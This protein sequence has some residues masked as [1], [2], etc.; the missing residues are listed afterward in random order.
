[1]ESWMQE[2]EDLI[3]EIQIEKLPLSLR[4]GMYLY[5]TKPLLFSG[6]IETNRGKLEEELGNG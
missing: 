3:T 5:K 2:I 1:M 4:A 6:W